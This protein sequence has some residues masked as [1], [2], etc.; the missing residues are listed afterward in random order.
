MADPVTSVALLG[1]LGSE[2]ERLAAEI[3]EID[4]LIESMRGEVARLRA[5]D[6]QAAAGVT[7]VRGRA[8]VTADEALAAS[9]ELVAVL[10]RQGAMV[11]E[12]DSL[13]A[14]RKVLDRLDAQLAGALR[15]LGQLVE[16]AAPAGGTPIDETRLL[17][18]VVATQEEERRRIA[19]AVHDGPAQ[20]MANVVLQSEIAE[21]VF[22]MDADRARQELAALRAMVNRTLQS[23]RGFIFELRP[24]IL[25]DLGLVP[26]LR[27]YIQTVVDKYGV[28]VDFSSVGRDRRLPSDDEVSVFRL[29]QDAL[30]ERV[31]KA[32]A[33]DLAVAMDWRDDQVEI[34]VQSDGKA[35]ANP[36]ELASGLSRGE[37]VALLRGE[38]T[39]ETRP[40]G[41][42]V[43][44]AKVPI[45]PASQMIT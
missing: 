39:Q 34:R 32:E 42:T 17:R 23:L 35:L 18:A 41:Q 31:Q 19:R 29:V 43:L 20:A 44:I 10:R 11:A 38:A 3:R 13:L 9:D 36:G 4:A 2:Q 24:M 27:R 22:A 14:K 7:A 8:G 45:A 15:H 28:H 12:L 37:R 33:K 21:R 6:D 5:R 16:A 40:D 1:E 30:V 26:T 25:D